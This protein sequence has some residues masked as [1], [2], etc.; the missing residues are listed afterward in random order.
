MQAG[1]D[2][3][4]GNVSFRE[5]AAIRDSFDFE[6]L[7]AHDLASIGAPR[8]MWAEWLHKQEPASV[9]ED[10][11][12]YVDAETLMLSRSTL[13]EKV[14]ER[15]LPQSLWPALWSE[16]ELFADVAH[17][18]KGRVLDATLVDT[19]T[20]TLRTKTQALY[21]QFVGLL[22]VDNPKKPNEQG[23]LVSVISSCY[24]WG[25]GENRSRSTMSVSSLI[26]STQP[27]G[28]AAE[29]KLTR[30]CRPC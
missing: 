12:C 20:K 29:V 2:Y 18:A 26:K 3:R 23:W 9:R 24:S 4:V 11:G 17:D 7:D 1:Y 19:T 16:K 30:H 15:Q 13:K 21:D 14:V 5:R 6:G 22:L 10:E 25:Q 8:N 27:V 28:S